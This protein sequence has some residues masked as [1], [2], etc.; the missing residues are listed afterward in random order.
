MPTFN[1]TPNQK[2]VLNYNFYHAQSC[3]ELPGVSA[4]PSKP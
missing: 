3:T 4:H 2:I 1:T